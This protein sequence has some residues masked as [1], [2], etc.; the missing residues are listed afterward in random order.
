MNLIR[1]MGI[2]HNNRKLGNK[3]EIINLPVYIS[4]PAWNV[5]VQTFTRITGL[6]NPLSFSSLIIGLFSELNIYLMDTFMSYY[7]SRMKV[8]EQSS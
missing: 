3:V 8:S 2:N 4:W 5:T 1:G 7:E 6:I